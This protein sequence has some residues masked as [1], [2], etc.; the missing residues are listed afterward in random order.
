MP[1]YGTFEQLYI[2]TLD[3]QFEL[4]Q[5]MA[6][7]AQPGSDEWKAGQFFLQGV[8]TQTRNALGAT[9]VL[10]QMELIDSATD[11][12]SLHQLFASPAFSGIPDLFNISVSPDPDD[13]SKAV[14]Y[15]AGPALGLPDVTYYEGD[16][17]AHLAAQQA[18]QSAATQLFQLI[19]YTPEQAQQAAANAYAFEATLA[20]KMLSPVDAQD[21]SVIDNPTPVSVFQQ[22]YPLL[23]WEAYIE[24]AG[25]RADSSTIVIDSEVELM[26]D[27]QNI[28]TATPI[29]TIQD[30]L[31]LQMLMIASDYPERRFPAGA[32]RALCGDVWGRFEWRCGGRR[33]QLGQCLPARCARPRLC[34]DLLLPRGKGAGGAAGGQSQGSVR[35]PLAAQPLDVRCHQAAGNPEAAGHDRQ[36]RLSRTNGKA[37]RTSRLG[38]SYWDTAFDAMAMQTRMAMA[39]AGMPIDPNQWAMSPQTVNA[40]YNPTANDITFPAAILQA[41]FFDPN[42]DPASNYGA[43]GYVIGHEIT[44]AFDLQGAQFDLHGNYADWWTASDEDAFNGRNEAVVAGVWQLRSAAGSLH[45]RPV[46]RDRERRR[47]GRHAGRVRRAATGSAT[48]GRPRRDRRAFPEP[49]LLHRGSASLAGEGA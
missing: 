36:G 2:E 16:A 43:I 17:E 4:I 14:Y 34:R 27:L 41:P 24:A 42:A 11:L 38:D 6:T 39:S 25:G 28:V 8:D 23:D 3:Q 19:G 13:S 37:T 47:H 5:Q 15:L 46:D 10:P 48:A 32:R 29:A 21:F 45:R 20:S 40:G 31:K 9:P 18:Y 49:A 12:Q 35:I 33:A 1:S 44:H 26:T 7:G 22:M 30:Y